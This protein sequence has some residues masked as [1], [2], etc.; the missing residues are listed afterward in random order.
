MRREKR[1]TE[2]KR[3]RKSKNSGEQQI[4]ED[5]RGWRAERGGGK[6]RMVSVEREQRPEGGERR[7]ES[8]ETDRGG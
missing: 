2:R 6:R 8:G 3:K 5:A 4:V 7:A 1:E